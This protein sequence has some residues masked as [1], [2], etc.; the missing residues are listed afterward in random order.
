MCVQTTDK[1]QQIDSE[2]SLHNIVK[3]TLVYIYENL[4]DLNGIY[5]YLEVLYVRI[6]VSF[7]CFLSYLLPNED[8]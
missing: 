8:K 6:L 3:Y 2:N 7:H 1:R 4:V 5:A